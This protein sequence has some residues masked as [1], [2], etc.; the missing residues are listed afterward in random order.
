VRAWQA[1]GDV[2]RQTVRRHHVE[3]YSRHEHDA[4]AAR[5]GAARADAFENRDF[6]GQIQIVDTA[7]QARVGER[8]P[9][10]RERPRCIHQDRDIA[11][12]PIDRRC[13]VEV[14]EPMLETEL[15]RH[16][17]ERSVVAAADQRLDAALDHRLG[18]EASDVTI[19]AVD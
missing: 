9:R 2:C 8:P 1:G 19:R 18:G 13:I 15:G 16:R 3:P 17:R 6:A 4:A 14:G 12:H 5:G 7:A 10:R 11:Q